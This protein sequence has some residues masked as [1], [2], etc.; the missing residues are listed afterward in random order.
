MK[1]FIDENREAY[2]ADLEH[3]PI[4][5]GHRPVGAVTPSFAGRSAASL[6]K[7]SA[8]SAPGRSGGK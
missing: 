1:A 6:S 8:S 3:G 2:G 5:D 4:P 7:T